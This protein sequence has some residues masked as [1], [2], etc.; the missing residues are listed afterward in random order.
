MI[1]SVYLLLLILCATVKGT[2]IRYTVQFESSNSTDQ[3][4]FL[5]YL[6]QHHIQVNVR[7][8]FSTIM[9]GMSVEL[10]E[11]EHLNT[12]TNT[13]M[14]RPAMFLA[15]TLR[16]CPYIHRYWPGKRY[17]RPNVIR[18]SIN[19]AGYIDPGLPNLG[20]AHYMTGVDLAKRDGWTGHGIKVGILDSG[21]DYKHP[22]LG[23]CFGENCLVR[24]GYDLVGDTYGDTTS[25]IPDDD[26]R[27]LCDGHGT[28]VAGILAAN[29]TYKGFEGVAPGVVLGAWRIF[30]CQGD[31]DD[32]IILA[33]A[34]MAAKD[35]MDIINLSLGG[36]VS[37]WGE[38][39]LAV[40]LS[41]LADR[42]IIVVVAQGNEG[43]DGIARTPSPAI[44]E[45]VIAVG[46]V[47]NAHR[48]EQ[49]LRVYH[50]GNEL[51]NYE[52]ALTDGPTLLTHDTDIEFIPLVR[53]TR[54]QHDDNDDDDDG[55]ETG[56]GPIKQ[57]ISGK[58]VLAQR[59]GCDDAQKAI[60][61]QKAG[62]LGLLIYNVN[63]QDDDDDNMAFERNPLVHIPV[64]SLR[65][66]DGAT[67][68]QHYRKR[69]GTK[70]S[71]KFVSHPMAI[72]SAGLMSGFSTWGPDP[73]L[74]VKP[75][76]TGVGGSMYSTFPLGLGS[77]STMSGTSMATPYISGCVALLMQ[78][79]GKAPPVSI[80]RHLLNHAKPVY[81]S[82]GV[83][84]ESI[85]K[86]GA[87]LVQ[88][89]DSILATTKVS[90][91]KI[92]LN[93][94]D[95]FQPLT[96]LAIENTSN[97]TKRYQLEHLPTVAVSGYNFKKSAVP[98][99]HATYQV[100]NGF[101][102]FEQDS[103]LLEPMESKNISVHF[104]QPPMD[105]HD[106]DQIT[107]PLVYGGFL[108][109]QQ[110]SVGDDDDM[111]DK[112]LHVPYFGILGNQHDLPILDLV[113]GYP[114]IG[115]VDGTLIQPDDSRNAPKMIPTYNFEKGEKL[116]LYIRLGSPTALLKCELIKLDK[117]HQE[118]VIGYVSRF[119]NA[120][121][122]RNDN[123]R[124]NYDYSIHWN[125][126]VALDYRGSLSPSAA[127]AKAAEMADTQN[128]LSSSTI[129]T[130]PADPGVYHLRLSALKI[131]GD[132]DRK[133]D[134]E[135]W[136]SLEFGIIG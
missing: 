25:P 118:K 120:W 55:N 12:T 124:D 57:D 83:H 20:V 84:L 15:Q 129:K 72:K 52:Y 134:W 60:E 100:T 43:R 59:G 122:P 136:N 65:G 115:T 75:D 24:Y 46:S 117:H 29:D 93:D 10:E 40:A 77:Y 91:Y 86:Q 87:G 99:R 50:K 113:K 127:A 64:A 89:Y 17:A 7:Y 103:F 80:I 135:T 94:T 39:A 132:A 121:V 123:G 92:S 106:I 97:V 62:G 85:A 130:Y 35:G 66:Q 14:I 125:G 126:Q 37:A 112:A 41:N 18:S 107:S 27:D 88:I 34:D 31:T 104:Q 108:R 96:Q 42:G 68:L 19:V 54:N 26:P 51:D 61:V 48:A 3:K 119:H 16:R 21:V 74:H 79:T 111:D 128:L 32:D 101:V 11:D 81:T 69:G 58:M 73:E 9:N 44:G 53:Q 5:D 8:Q 76:I 109:I 30:G 82:S 71:M 13:N 133:E 63:H 38:D 67:M 47:D 6:H 36:G 105:H 56:C 116:H 110:S 102:Q 23:G 98:T 33:A 90:P 22:A 45:H 2:K 49:M 95:H 131:F 28:H 70:L 78:A 4:A 1:V 114:Y